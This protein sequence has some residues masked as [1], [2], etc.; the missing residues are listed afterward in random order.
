MNHPRF[1]TIIAHLDNPKRFMSFSLDE[2]L[3]L[4]LGIMLLVTSNHKVIVG[5]FS[6]SLLSLL[7][8]LKHGQGP[9]YLL[10]Q[11]YW[12]MPSYV[13]QGLVSNVP[14]SYFRKWRG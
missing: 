7:R 2:L 8:Y 3:V 6:L 9:R 1:Y 12:F 10:V 4:A 5:G 14:K 11:L 13:S